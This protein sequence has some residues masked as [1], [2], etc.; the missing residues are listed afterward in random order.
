MMENFL[1]DNICG[2]SKSASSWYVPNNKAIHNSR[3]IGRYLLLTMFDELLYI[4][5]T[6]H[7]K[8]RFDYSQKPRLICERSRN[9]NEFYTRVS[10][11]IK[12]HFNFEHMLVGRYSRTQNH[13]AVKTNWSSISF[14]KKIHSLLNVV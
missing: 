6:I 8:R 13:A 4:H 3:C 2:P 7:L 14:E 11:T 10:C 1:R 12:W 9:S 5:L